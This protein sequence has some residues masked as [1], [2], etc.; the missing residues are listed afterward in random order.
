MGC[1]CVEVL[2]VKWDLEISGSD[3]WDWGLGATYLQ[4]THLLAGYRSPGR[5]GR[6]LRFCLS[7][8]GLESGVSYWLTGHSPFCPLCVV[9]GC[10]SEFY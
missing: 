8:E 3:E 9:E 5:R 10:V 6:G 2:V 7:M 4:E 1:V